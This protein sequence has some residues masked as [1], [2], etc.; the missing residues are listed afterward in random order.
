MIEGMFADRSQA[1]RKLAE[2]LVEYKNKKALVLALPRGGV[3]VGYEIA[4]VL[5]CSLDTIVAR[6][7]GAP[8]NPEYAVGA[9]APGGIRV[10]DESMHGIEKVI[11][12]E[13]REMERRIER[14]GSGSYAL[15]VH[16]EVVILVDDGVATGKTASAAL[17]YARA[18]YPKAKL[19]FAAPVGAQDS[20]ARIKREADE[21]VL[22]EIPPEFMAVGEWY[23]SFPQLRDEEVVEYLE[24]AREF[25]PPA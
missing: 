9:I 1:G 10:L 16:P 11:E 25:A 3:P 17:A 19:V 8:G 2:A 15:G 12:N 14:Y 22:L 13:T 5:H 7:V 24:K 18:A 23:V 21:V 20:L 6:K 4:K